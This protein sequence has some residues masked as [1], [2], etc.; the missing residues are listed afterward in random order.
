MAALQAQP[1]IPPRPQLL[2]ADCC[3][4]LPAVNVSSRMESTGVPGRIHVSSAFAALLPQEKWEARG[5]LDVKGKGLM[6]TYLID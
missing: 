5:G 3:S 4:L 6:Q 2:P 1:C